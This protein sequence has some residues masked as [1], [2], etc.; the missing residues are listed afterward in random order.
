MELY[1]SMNEKIADI[2]AIDGTPS[3]LYASAYIKDLRA[4]NAR[5]KDEISQ[6]D[7][8]AERFAKEEGFTPDCSPYYIANEH[9]KQLEQ[10]RKE[11]LRDVLGFLW[12]WNNGSLDRVIDAYKERYGVEVKE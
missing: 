9:K 1:E 10:I 2:I 4:E 3:S 11:T 7:M 12:G 6:R 8:H 5:L